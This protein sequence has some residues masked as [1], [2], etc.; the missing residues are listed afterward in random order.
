MN[1]NVT[2]QGGGNCIIGSVNGV[3]Y[4]N[5][6]EVPPPPKRSKGLFSNTIIIGSKIFTDGYE[7]KDGQWKRTLRALWHLI[8]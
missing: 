7:W 5:G 6:E 4:I 1:N 8:F 3:I 2:I